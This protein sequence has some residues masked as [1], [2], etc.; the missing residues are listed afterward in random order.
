MEYWMVEGLSHLASGLEVPKNAVLPNNLSIRRLGE[1]G[2]LLCDSISVTYPWKLNVVSKKWVATRRVFQTGWYDEL[3]KENSSRQGQG[4]LEVQGCHY[5][6]EGFEDLLSEERED[7]SSGQ[8]CRDVL[9][10]DG[11]MEQ[12]KTL[13]RHNSD[14]SDNVTL[15]EGADRC[16]EDVVLESGAPGSVVVEVSQHLGEATLFS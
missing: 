13:P 2:E 16:S 5:Q 7:H 6:D 15:Q 9:V 14:E 4:L 8:V 12:H 3:M 10:D 11:D 1:N